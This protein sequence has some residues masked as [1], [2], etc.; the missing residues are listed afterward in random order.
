[1]NH[2]LKYVLCILCSLLWIVNGFADNQSDSLKIIQLLQT[3]SKFLYEDSAKAH[4]AIDQAISIAQGKNNRLLLK[5]LNAKSTLF[6]MQS[7]QSKAKKTIDQA[8]SLEKRLQKNKDFSST[9]SNLGLYYFNNADF[10]QSISAHIQSAEI[11][12]KHENAN[13]L[14]RSYNNIGNVYI[15]LKDYQKALTYYQEALKIAVQHKL[16]G[17]EAHVLGNLGIVYTNLNKLDSA[18]M[19]ILQSL[20][21]HQEQNN[22]IQVSYNYSNLGKLYHQMENY[23]SSRFYFKAYYK[24]SEQSNNKMGMISALLDL[25]EIEMEHGSLNDAGRYLDNLDTMLMKRSSAEHKSLFYQLRSDYL[26]ETGF[27]EEALNARKLYEQ[28]KDSVSNKELLS[29]IEELEIKYQ[30]EKKERELLIQKA[31]LSQRENQLRLV[32]LLGLLLIISSIFIFILLRQRR[33]NRYQRESIAA[34]TQAQEKERQRVARDLHDSVGS[35]LANLKNLLTATHQNGE[36]IKLLSQ[37]NQEI[38]QISHDM[39]PGTLKKFG[40]SAAIKSELENVKKSDHLDTKFVA[41]GING[42]LSKDTE[43][44]LYRILQE[45]LQNITKHA[46]ATKVIVSLTGDDNHLNLMIE[47][48]GV[49]FDL[50]SG[51]EGLGLK[52]IKTRIRLLNGQLKVDSHPKMGTIININIPLS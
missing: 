27:F 24:L 9:Y 40:L 5:A 33:E 10:N 32:I 21:I 44:H 12:E 28:H 23:D 22:T 41:F 3:Y 45:A 4:Q 35:M 30:S 52:S 8:L 34:I 1:M 49:G 11:A 39:M 6:L 51:S 50:Q 42:N 2:L 36:E 38:R 37:V 16:R 29:D 7:Q 15:K 17:G 13:S 31:Q 14:A 43:V 26:A 19:V 48:N 25:T 47:D 18:I 20:K 46:Q